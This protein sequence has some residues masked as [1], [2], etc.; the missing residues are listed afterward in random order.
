MLIK[1]YGKKKFKIF[2]KIFQEYSKNIS[3][4]TITKIII[5]QIGVAHVSLFAPRIDV[6]GCNLN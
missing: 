1:K 5:K 6:C 3:Q 4:K 2:S